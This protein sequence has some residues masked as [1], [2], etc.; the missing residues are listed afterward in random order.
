MARLPA[1]DL[2]I[3]AVSGKLGRG[4]HTTR[5]VE[6]FELP[7]GG[8]LADTPG[9]NQPDIRCLPEDLGNCFPEIRDR[10]Q[11]A[12]CQFADCL[13]QREPGCIVQGDWER[14]PYYLELLEDC[15]VQSQTVSDSPN[16]EDVFKVKVTGDGQIQHEPRLQ[17][18]KYRRISR[19]SR[20]QTLQELRYELTDNLENLEERDEEDWDVD[21]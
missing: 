11:N 10:L 6:L 14:Y 20:Q 2:R 12:Q 15:M 13:H 17:A 9:F 4:R 16:P 8:L 3:N 1:I 19:R 7:E 5:H 18:K 21:L